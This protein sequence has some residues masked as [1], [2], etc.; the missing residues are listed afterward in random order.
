MRIDRCILYIFHLVRGTAQMN[1]RQHSQQTQWR[2]WH[3]SLEDT[4]GVGYCAPTSASDLQQ[5]TQRTML[6]VRLPSKTLPRPTRAWRRAEPAEPR[7][8]AQA[9]LATHA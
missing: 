2:D 9:R 5:I 4:S 1:D 3:E 7:P 6:T 8:G